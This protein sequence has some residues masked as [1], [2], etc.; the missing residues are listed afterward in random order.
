MNKAIVDGK[1]IAHAILDRVKR[2]IHDAGRKPRL[3][4]VLIGDNPASETYIRRKQQAADY[5]GMA[6]ELHRFP[7]GIDQDLVIEKIKRLSGSGV[8]G[9]IVQL[10][11]PKHF[12]KD[13][14]LDA[15]DPVVDVD[16]L[17][18]QR[19][20]ALVRGSAAI[21]PPTLA[22]ILEILGSCGVKLKKIKVVVVGQGDLIGRPL[23]V[24]L[25]QY[26]I[27]L[28]V[29]GLGTEDLSKHTKTADV[30]ITGVGKP[31]LVTAAMVKKGA[32]VVDAGVS[33]RGRKILGDVEWEA[34]AKRAKF[35][36]PTPGGV[37]PVT[38]AK[39]LENTLACAGLH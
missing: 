8:H 36:T 24:V 20:G 13:A 4:V 14:V 34:A 2:R 12:D 38:V 7:A 9:L 5:V 19:Q 37:G 21:V 3:A 30:L 6:F 26:P 1:A 28:T 22:A 27:T 33:M 25:M 31:G 18:K 29:C 16:C 32:V 10:P 15:I 11:L 17:T 23:A 35:I 39:L